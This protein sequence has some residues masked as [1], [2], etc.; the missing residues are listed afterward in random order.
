MRRSS[1]EIRR[2][3][4]FEESEAAE[5]ERGAGILVPAIHKALADALRWC[6]GDA[7]TLYERLMKE[8]NHRDLGKLPAVK[9][10]SK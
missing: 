7:G 9:G 2:A 8:R 5:V 10:G 4:K 3:I 1:A 6:A